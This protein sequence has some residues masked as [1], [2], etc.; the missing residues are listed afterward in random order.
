MEENNLGGIKLK[1]IEYV[2]MLV[3]SKAGRRK[4]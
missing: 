4:M 3:F 2:V 1:N